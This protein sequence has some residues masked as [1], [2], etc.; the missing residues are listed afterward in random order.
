MNSLFICGGESGI[1]YFID[2]SLRGTPAIQYQFEAYQATILALFARPP[3]GKGTNYHVVSG[4]ALGH[5][6]INS[7]EVALQSRHPLQAFRLDSAIL[8]FA[9][10][11]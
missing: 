4:D 9:R 5:V 11:S 10:L 6:Q 1:L 3:R 2:P 8:Q 7:L